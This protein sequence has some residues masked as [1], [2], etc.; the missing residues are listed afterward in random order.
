MNAPS[1]PVR[2]GGP[3][4]GQGGLPALLDGL[5]RLIALFCRFVIVATGIVL[6][7]VM[8]ANVVARYAF[9]SG[10]FR[11]AQELP[12]LLFPWFIL[13]GIA[14]A[15]QGGAHMAVEWLY[16]K[17]AERGKVAVFLLAHLCA[18]ASFVTLGWQA[19]IVAEIAGVEHSPILRLP[20]SIG[21]YA[22]A[23]GAALVALVTLIAAARVARLG[24]DARPRSNVE[25][26]PL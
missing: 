25:E 4:G 3:G 15:A 1:D 10:G 5:D 7:S 6:A 14:L 24:W 12:T 9:A 19:L 13:A 8:T 20:N 16:D 23:L 22:L 18:A 11:F 21:Y 26:M 2:A 17:V